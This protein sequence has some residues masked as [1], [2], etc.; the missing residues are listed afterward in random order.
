[1]KS[2][3]ILKARLDAG[4]LTVGCIMTMHIW[5]DFIELARTVGLD[6]VIVDLEHLDHDRETVAE[7]CAV[8]RMTDFP[9][10]VRPQRTDRDTVSLAADL[11]PAGL[12]LPMIDSTAKLDE[13]QKGLYMPPRGERRVGGR[14]MRW[15]SD[16]G[17]DAVKAGLEDE[18]V[19]IPQ[20]ESPAGVAAA[21][22]IAAHPLTTAMG[23]GPYDLS[24]RLGVCWQ[25]DAP[26]L[27][28]AMATV[29]AAADGAGKAM[30]QIGDGQKLRA[31]GYHFICAAEPTFLLQHTL[32]GLVDGLR[33]AAPVDGT[34]FVP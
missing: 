11:G 15:V 9:V 32:K 28:A 8:G 21:A 20:I 29:R 17:Y 12:L 27:Q 6:Y 33:D 31:A 10:L 13:V 4:E 25:P 26:E 3:Q 34:A 18:L 1:M 7:I 14:A 22:A 30:W 16:F 19:I 2:A 23:I 5:L 24:A